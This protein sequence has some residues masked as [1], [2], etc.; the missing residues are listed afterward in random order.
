METEKPS[1]ASRNPITP[2]IRRFLESM[3][4]PCVLSTLRRDGHPITSST[5]YGQML[6]RLRTHGERVIIRIRPERVRPWGIE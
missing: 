5:W 1:L 4:V 3:R 6:D 2:E